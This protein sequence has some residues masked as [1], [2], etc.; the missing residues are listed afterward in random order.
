MKHQK[1]DICCCLC[2]HSMVDVGLFH[3]IFN[4]TLLSLWDAIT[5]FVTNWHVCVCVSV[6]EYPFVF[7]AVWISVVVCLLSRF[8]PAVCAT[9]QHSAKSCYCCHCVE[10]VCISC[11]HTQILLSKEQVSVCWNSKP[12]KTVMLLRSEWLL[13]KINFHNRFAHWLVLREHII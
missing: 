10:A 12:V 6:Y 7:L 8:H 13:F 4:E 5:M 11:C 1:K 9:R 3:F 2:V